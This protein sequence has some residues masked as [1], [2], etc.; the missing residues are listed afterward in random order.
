VET[1]TS[2]RKSPHQTKPNQKN[3]KKIVN[4]ILEKQ[5]FLITLICNYSKAEHNGSFFRQ[6]IKKLNHLNTEQRETNRET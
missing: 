3:P 5:T 6:K 4:S 1:W 2:D